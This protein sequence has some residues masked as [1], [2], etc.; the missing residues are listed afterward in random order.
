MSPPPYRVTSKAPS[1]WGIGCPVPEYYGEY[2]NQTCPNTC[3]GQQCDAVT[4]YCVNGCLSG[5][6]GLR[7]S[8]FNLAL[9]SS[10]WQQNNFPGKEKDW[11]AD[12]AVDGKYTDRSAGGNQCTQSADG[13]QTATLRVDL[14]RVVS[15]SHINIYYRTDNV[16]SPGAYYGRF[17]GF[18]LYVSNTTVKDDGYLCFHEIQTVVGTPTENQ[19]ISCPVHGRYVIYYNERRR[20]VTYPSYFSKYAYNELCELEVYGCPDQRYFGEYCDQLCPENCQEQRCDITTGECL[21]C[22]PGYQGRMCSHLCGKQMYGLECSLSCGNCSDGETCHHVNGTCLRGC[23]EGV[24]GEK[25]QTACQPGYYG[26]DCIHECSVN[27]GV[28]RRC[29]RFTG[30]CGG[31]CQPGWKGNLCEQA[32]QAGYYGKDC[33]HECNI[34]CGVPKRCDRF[35]GECEGGCQPG[36]KGNLCD[37]ECIPGFYGKHCMRN[38]SKSCGVSKRCDRITGHCEGGCQPGWQGIQCDKKCGVGLYGVI[39]NQTCGHCL[40]DT[41]CHHVNG[42]CLEGC[43]SGYEGSLCMKV[44]RRSYWGENCKRKCHTDCVNQICHHESGV[45]ET[46]VKSQM[47]EACSC[48]NTTTIIS[49]IVS[50]LIVISGSVLNYLIWKRNQKLGELGKHNT[51]DELHI[52]EKADEKI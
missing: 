29:N 6:Q 5:Y 43:S 22:K 38:C 15:I 25:C 28:T 19:T 17:A 30:E 40:N 4:G 48:G 50:V 44:C 18:F 16:P 47:C 10:A 27:C 46:Y 1:P 7:C 12:K 51:Y 14:Q 35:T 8:Y 26:K 31:G 37:Q 36:W 39:C 3:P 11:G 13:K 42:S 49:I 32:C 2:C 33:V 23:S 21:G 20:G 9:R 45:C 24:E 41:Q 52:Y 34:D